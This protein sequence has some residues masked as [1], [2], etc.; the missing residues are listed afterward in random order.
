MDFDD[1][2]AIYL[3][4]KS[5]SPFS[6]VKL[7]LGVQWVHHIP[8]NTFDKGVCCHLTRIELFY[9]DDNFRCIALWVSAFHALCERAKVDHIEV[10]M[11]GKKRTKEERFCSLQT[12][13]SEK[14]LLP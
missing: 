6:M 2:L 13:W 1:F 14:Y 9:F 12:S 8:A 7:Y 11:H 4:F 3:I 5:K 10:Y